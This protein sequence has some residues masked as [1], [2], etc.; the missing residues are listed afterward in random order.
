MHL[1]SYLLRYI[2]KLSSQRLVGQAVSPMIRV[3]KVILLQRIVVVFTSKP[4]GRA[5]CTIHGYHVVYKCFSNSH[6]VPYNVS[7]RL[8]DLKKY[9]IV[10]QN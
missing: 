1:S 7:C 9:K 10:N 4:S 8:R 6:R 5:L 3:V 2:T